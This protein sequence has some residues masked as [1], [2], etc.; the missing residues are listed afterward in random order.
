MALEIPL[1]QSNFG[2]KNISF[3]VLSIWIK[4]NNT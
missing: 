1:R 2:Q 4:L 3:M